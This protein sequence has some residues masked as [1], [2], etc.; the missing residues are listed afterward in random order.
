MQQ[1][2]DDG[3]DHT[4]GHQQDDDP[5]GWDDADMEVPDVE[6]WDRGI[7]TNA[8]YDVDVPVD[9]N[10]AVAVKEGKVMCWHIE[11]LARSIRSCVDL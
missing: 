8:S 3:L 9:L 11:P 2:G 7:L 1:H 5:D 10:Q 4:T 6:W